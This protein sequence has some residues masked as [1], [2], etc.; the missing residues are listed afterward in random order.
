MITVVALC[1]IISVI[2]TFSVMHLAQHGKLDFPSLCAV[3]T[4]AVFLYAIY[5]VADWPD[6]YLQFG[7]FS[8]NIVELH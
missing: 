4:I 8:V 2:I 3:L 5:E 1:F 7:V 6:S